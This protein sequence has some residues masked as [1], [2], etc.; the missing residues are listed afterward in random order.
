MTWHLALGTALA[1]LLSSTPLMTG[2]VEG[3]ASVA[4][5]PSEEKESATGVKASVTPDPGIRRPAHHR[6]PER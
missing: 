4:M 2:V 5:S 3:Q 6:R 1:A